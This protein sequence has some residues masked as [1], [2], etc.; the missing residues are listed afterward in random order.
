VVGTG[1]TPKVISEY[2][3]DTALSKEI[4][5]IAQQAAEELGQWK[6]DQEPLNASQVEFYWADPPVVDV[7]PVKANE[8]DDK[9]TK[10][11]LR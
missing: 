8:D 2:V 10:V 6:D 5:A 1:L 7:E 4:R 9:E 3:V 11:P